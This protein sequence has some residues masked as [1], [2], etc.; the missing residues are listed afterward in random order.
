MIPILLNLPYCR[1]TYV[2]DSNLIFFVVVALV[3]HLSGV[4]KVTPNWVVV[5]VLVIYLSGAEKITRF[6]HCSCPCCSLVKC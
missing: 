4:E 3:I 5:V 6:C 1:Y 2:L